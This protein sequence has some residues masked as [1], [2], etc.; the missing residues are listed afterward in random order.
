MD[1]QIR[2]LFFKGTR[3]DAV[4]IAGPGQEWKQGVLE[5]YYNYLNERRWWL[6]RMVAMELEKGAQVWESSG[7]LSWQDLSSPVGI[8]QLHLT[9][10]FC[11]AVGWVSDNQTH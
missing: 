4:R 9:F 8:W 5:D 2:D 1:A 7:R 6:E 10:C 3:V 11:P